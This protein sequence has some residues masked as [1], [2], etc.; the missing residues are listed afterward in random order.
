ML[1][2]FNDKFNLSHTVNWVS[3]GDHFPGSFNKMLYLNFI[4]TPL[5]YVSPLAGVTKIS[6]DPYSTIYSYYTKV[7]VFAFHFI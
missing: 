5:G 1:G 6:T 4:D 7:F 2:T 3:F